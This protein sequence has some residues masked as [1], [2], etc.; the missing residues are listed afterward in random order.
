[1][2]LIIRQ[3]GL[4][5][6]WL[7][8]FL[9]IGSGPANDAPIRVSYLTGALVT[10][11]GFILFHMG[12]QMKA[13]LADYRILAVILFLI[14]EATLWYNWSNAPE[15]TDWGFTVGVLATITGLGWGM[16]EYYQPN[17]VKSRIQKY[18]EI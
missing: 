15:Q 13:G 7:G 14:G 3:I 12:T 8:V 11:E 16:M 2:K 9:L 17:F 5:M 6:L 1:M 18:P 4:S 10:V